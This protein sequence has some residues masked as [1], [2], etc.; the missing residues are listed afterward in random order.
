VNDWR[1]ELETRKHEETCTLTTRGRRTGRPHAVTI[2]FAVDGPGRIYLSTLRLG[3]D[4]P[5]N[6]IA[7]PHVSFQV[8]DLV[9]V[10][11]VRL[12]EDEGAAAE[13]TKAIAQKYWGAWLARWLG[14]RPE[15]V[16]EML[17]SEAPS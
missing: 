17:P 10:G 11:T 13:G 2:W 16:F 6:A 5:Q 4:W 3:R 14:L 8:G 15:G 12:L 1:A 7:D 9:L